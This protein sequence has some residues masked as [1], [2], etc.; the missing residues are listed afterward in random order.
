MHVGELRLSRRALA[1]VVALALVAAGAGGC[2]GGSTG[3]GTTEPTAS[4]PEATAPP[5]DATQP[6]T[7]ATTTPTQTETLPSYRGQRGS[8]TGESDAR[9]VRVPATFTVVGRRLQPSTITVP[10]FLAIQLTLRASDRQ[11]HRLRLLTPEAQ[12]LD[13]GAEQRKVS[14][15]IPGQR[16]GRYKLRLD[17]EPKPIATL[18]VGGEVGP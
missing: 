5:A 1:P 8:S 18:V 10:P 7:G 17:Y 13:L 4:A 15:L 3:N 14:L 16:A 6:G 2:G 11:F 12:E 9:G